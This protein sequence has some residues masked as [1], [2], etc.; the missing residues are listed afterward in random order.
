[1]SQNLEVTLLNMNLTDDNVIAACA[2]R[3]DRVTRFFGP[4]FHSNVQEFWR[5]LGCWKL[6]DVS[7]QRSP[8]GFR[9][10]S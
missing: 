8:K 3:E 5:L 7:L 6:V 2:N 1:M 10:N 9:S 4:V